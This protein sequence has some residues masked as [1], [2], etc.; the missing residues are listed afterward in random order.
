MARPSTYSACYFS[1]RVDYSVYQGANHQTIPFVSQNK[2]VRWI[3]DRFARKRAAS[4]C[5]P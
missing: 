3:A 5:S 4:Y 2:Y 1:H